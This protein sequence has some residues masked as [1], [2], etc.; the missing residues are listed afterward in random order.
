MFVRVAFMFFQG[1][2]LQRAAVAAPSVER[3]TAAAGPAYDVT[4]MQPGEAIEPT[5]PSEPVAPDAEPIP[6]DTTAELLGRAKPR[7]P[8][9]ARGA[10]K[11]AAPKARRT[12][13]AKKALPA[14]AA[15]SSDK[16]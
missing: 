1:P 9:A 11:A 4:E 7:R 14:E 13:R 8:R 5:E 16:S 3:E 12:S 6:V 15:D 2:A 10:R